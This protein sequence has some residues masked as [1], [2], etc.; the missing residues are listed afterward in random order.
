MFYGIDT[1]GEC[2]KTFCGCNVLN[3]VLS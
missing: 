2:Y 3:F 1:M